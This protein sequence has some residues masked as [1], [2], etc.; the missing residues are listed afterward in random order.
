MATNLNTSYI[1]VTFKILGGG[2]NTT[3]GPLGVGDE[4][5]SDLQNVEFNKFGSV[6]QRN[7]YTVLNTNILTGTCQG[8]YW[9]NAPSAQYAVTVNQ[10]YIYKM[11]NLDGTWDNITGAVNLGGFYDS[12]TKLLM[13]YDGIDRGLTFT[14][15][16]TLKTITNTETYD[17]YTL[18]M[19]HTSGA[20]LSTVISDSSLGTHTVTCVHETYLTTE[21]PNFNGSSI[22][23]PNVST[24][25]LVV[26]FNGADGDKADYTAETGQTVSMGTTLANDAQ[27][28]TTQKKF[29]SA[30]LV[31]THSDYV[32]I[33]DSDNFYFADKPFTIDF[34][35]RFNDLSTSQGFWS[36]YVDKNN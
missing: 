23:I 11:D 7:G 10:G 34:W 24:T 19:L 17:A 21:N 13:H 33:P 27:L 35:V 3:S 5:S 26:N 18:L 30:S 31:L 16:A 8:L 1:P 4:E 14:D 12:Y 6:S 32:T 25:V 29:G 36:Q 2:L 22:L 9:Y 28:N 20:N 15:L